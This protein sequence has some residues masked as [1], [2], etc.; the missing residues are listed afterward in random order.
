[1]YVDTSVDDA[2]MK[3]YEGGADVLLMRIE[4]DCTATTASS[5]L[6]SYHPFSTQ[7]SAPPPQQKK[8]GSTTDCSAASYSRG[9]ASPAA[10]AR[11]RSR[12]DPTQ[13]AN[14]CPLMGDGQERQ[15]LLAAREVNFEENS[16]AS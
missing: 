16:T 5:P 3:M 7:S 4:S 10:T 14:G 15:E 6:S 9:D 11:C 13:R 12:L 2:S 1:M 8:P